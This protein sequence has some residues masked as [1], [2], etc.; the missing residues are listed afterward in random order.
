MKKEIFDSLDR[1]EFM[2]QSL[3]TGTA[4][5]LGLGN[6]YSIAATDPPPEITRIRFP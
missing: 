5:Y 1:R 2:K 6:D 3:L 4:M